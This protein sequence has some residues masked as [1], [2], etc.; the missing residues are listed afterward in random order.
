MA[1]S[2]SIKIEVGYEDDG[3]II[4]VDIDKE[5][6]PLVRRALA[7]LHKQEQEERQKT[8]KLASTCRNCK[9]SQPRASYDRTLC[10]SKKIVAK[11]YKKVVRPTDTC[12]M[13]ERKED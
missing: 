6:V 2:E 5:N 10:C 8:K 13:F 12:E 11:Y 1:F 3:T 9:F 7:Y 4:F